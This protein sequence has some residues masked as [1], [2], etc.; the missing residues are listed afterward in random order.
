MSLM[1]C[2]SFHRNNGNQEGIA[3]LVNIIYE[4][5]DIILKKKETKRK[6]KTNP[7]KTNLTNKTPLI[8]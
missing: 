7:K 1:P 5:E 6:K 8:S 2:L 3:Q 4:L